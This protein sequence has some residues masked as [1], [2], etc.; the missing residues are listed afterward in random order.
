MTLSN[1]FPPGA[2]CLCGYCGEGV[3]V[4]LD[5]DRVPKQHQEEE[6]WEA[7]RWLARVVIAHPTLVCPHC[8][9]EHMTVSLPIPS[10]LLL[11]SS[12]LFT[13]PHLSVLSLLISLHLFSFS[14]VLSCSLRISVSSTPLI[15]II[16]MRE[17][18]VF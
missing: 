13:V 12:P 2:P 11:S 18:L 3:S 15:A 4:I 9:S 10:L 6:W 14:P 8:V 17:M 5:Q 16:K 7:R 1:G